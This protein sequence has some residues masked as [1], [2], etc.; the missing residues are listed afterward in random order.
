M[1]SHSMFDARPGRYVV[2]T[3]YFYNMTEIMIIHIFFNAALT[4]RI[5]FFV[6]VVMLSRVADTHCI[7]MYIKSVD[8]LYTRIVEICF[9]L[10]T[11]N[12]FRCQ[13]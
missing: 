6:V 4:I 10:S 5:S 7:W 11:T 12:G 9:G 2:G 8:D 1:R 13:I 3:L